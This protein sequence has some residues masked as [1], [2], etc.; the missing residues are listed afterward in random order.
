[1]FRYD[2]MGVEPGNSIEAAPAGVYDLVIVKASDE[3]DGMPRV[4][5]NGDHY[6]SVECEIANAN[7]WLGKKV[8]TNVTFLGK[9]E[10]G[11]PKKGAG[12][13]IHFLKLIGQPWEAPFDV[14]PEDWVGGKFRAKLIVTQDNKDRPK[15]EI[16]YYI[17][18]EKPKDESVPF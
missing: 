4:T 2:V 13:A 16:A 11:K 6:V 10:N 3:K 9:D 1:M 15:N 12:M 17:D 5:K 8:W 18:E 14:S 7:E